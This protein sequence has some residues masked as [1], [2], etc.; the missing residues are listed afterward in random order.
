M[1]VEAMQPSTVSWKMW[2]SPLSLCGAS[3]CSCA[4]T[5]ASR[6]RT[7][8][9]R[10]RRFNYSYSAS[11]NTWECSQCGG[12]QRARCVLLVRSYHHH[13]PSHLRHLPAVS[14]SDNSRGYPRVY[15]YRETWGRP[16]KVNFGRVLNGLRCVR[17][18]LLT[19]LY[20][21]LL[22]QLVTRL[23]YVLLIW[24]LI[25]RL[26]WYL[27]VSRSNFGPLSVRLLLNL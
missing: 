21:T 12:R 8:E 20:N 27:R 19:R 4:D 15:C 11:S 23:F 22:W 18:P 13:T 24:G 3:G 26:L 5:A 9:L 17:M 14:Q 16:S 6:T 10:H 2:R 25:Y 1:R 7:A